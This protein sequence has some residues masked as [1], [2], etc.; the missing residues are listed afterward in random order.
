MFADESMLAQ[1]NPNR[2]E[3]QLPPH[4]R[5]LSRV[6]QLGS[7]QRGYIL[8]GEHEELT[9]FYVATTLTNTPMFLEHPFLGKVQAF[10]NGLIVQISFM[11]RRA[12]WGWANHRELT[13]HRILRKK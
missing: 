11:N 9:P 1:G 6:K 3:V 4:S 7:E 8:K 5:A 2:R 13:L 12:I 10:S